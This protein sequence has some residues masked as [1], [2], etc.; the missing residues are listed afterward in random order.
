MVKIRSSSQRHF[1]MLHA[2]PRR[3]VS[4]DVSRGHL[5]KAFR[6]IFLHERK[7]LIPDKLVGQ[8]RVSEWCNGF[9]SRKGHPRRGDGR[10]A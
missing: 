9:E 7:A 6:S 2:G 8:M 5:E 3:G 10:A 1:S 4:P